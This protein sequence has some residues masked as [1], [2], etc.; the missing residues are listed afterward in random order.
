LTKSCVYLFAKYI[1]YIW[2]T[3]RET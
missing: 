3:K 1:N 2:K